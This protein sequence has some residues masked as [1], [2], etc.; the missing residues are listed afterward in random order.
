MRA[1]DLLIV[2][3]STLIG[4]ATTS[5]TGTGTRQSSD[6]EGRQAGVSVGTAGPPLAPAAE[7]QYR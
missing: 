7:R 1:K 2:A 4:C 3:A 6:G 5:S